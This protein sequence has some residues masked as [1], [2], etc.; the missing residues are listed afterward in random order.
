MYISKETIEY[1][2]ERVNIEDVVMRYVP[3]L[4][5]KGRNFTG[6]C[7]FHKEKTPSFTVSPDKQFFHCF[8]CNAGGNVF[9]FISKIENLSFT[10][11]VKFLA[12]MSGIEIKYDDSHD[13][14]S[15]ENI[16][17]INL[18]AMKVYH[19]CIKSKTG[20]AGMEYLLKRGLTAESIEKFMLG[21]APDSWD[22]ISTGLRKH[23]ASMEHAE[24]IGI[25]MRS[26]NNPNRFIDRFRNRVMFPI[27][28]R[29]SHVIAFGARTL[30]ADQQPKYLNSPESEVFQKRSVLY[31]L[32][33]AFNAIKE[34]DRAIIV[35]G[36]LD[37]IGCHQN[38]LEN[39]VAPLGTALTENHIRQLSHLCNEIVLLFDSDSAGINAALKSIETAKEFNVDIKIAVLPEDDPFD[40]IIKK[41]IM[42]LMIVIDK[43]MTP[44][45][46][47]I[48]T[49][50]KRNKGGNKIKTMR[51]LFEIVEKIELASERS[52]YMKKLSEILDLEEESLREDFSKLRKTDTKI[53]R[54][55]TDNITTEQIPY[56]S[57]LY[58]DLLELMIHYPEITGDVLIDFSPA[59][60]EDLLSR[61]IFEKIAELYTAENNLKIDKLFDFF[62]KEIEM[63]F[64][65]TSIQKKLEISNPKAAYTEIYVNL[66]LLD[67][68]SKIAKYAEMLKKSG[69]DKLEYLAEI[70]ILRR[71]KEKLTNYMYNR[72]SM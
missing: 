62:D 32:N 55:K 44:V 5:R 52:I 31:G 33:Q 63:E 56:S 24:K 46:F 48:D 22:S 59:D 69:N 47:Q 26:K 23:K 61:K 17:R 10:E 35:E 8:G 25:I 43:A 18:Y 49:V 14:G 27:F 2:R 42:E 9:T 57:R 53:S 4:K 30:K 16:R 13:A 37:V 7:P 72:G 68:N 64:L 19:S 67:I 6:L 71:E 41:G 58:R 28:D 1:V 54:Q 36:Y 11:S 21:M 29:K 60:I 66:K 34:M 12:D 20:Q 39:V 51:Q 3:S 65:N 45:D 40:F 15:I 38:G 70:E 50:M